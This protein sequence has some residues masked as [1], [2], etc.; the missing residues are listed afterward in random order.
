MAYRPGAGALQAAAAIEAETAV[1]RIEGSLLR[2]DIDD[3]SRWALES[4]NLKR[5]RKLGGRVLIQ[6]L[7]QKA[8]GRPS[9]CN[10]VGWPATT[11]RWRVPWGCARELFPFSGEAR[12][13]ARDVVATV[14]LRR[15]PW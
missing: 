9:R 3:P 5:P 15:H 10:H 11:G 7:T 13:D 12:T 8:V 14:V 4:S 1:D 6:D 2:K